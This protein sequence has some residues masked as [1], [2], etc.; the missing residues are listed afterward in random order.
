M[1]KEENKPDIIKF[2]LG[3]DMEIDK[4]IDSL[5][6]FFSVSVAAFDF[7]HSIQSAFR[8][9]MLTQ[10][11]METLHRVA[12]NELQKKEPDMKFIDHLLSLMEQQAEI[13]KANSQTAQQQTPPEPTQ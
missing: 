10:N 9:R 3:E 7:M 8:N 5:K 6:K 12:H 11:P 2:M 4:N 1:S 13:N